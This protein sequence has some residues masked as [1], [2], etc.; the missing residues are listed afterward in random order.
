MRVKIWP[1]KKREVVQP[2]EP[3]RPIMWCDKCGYRQLLSGTTAFGVKYIPAQNHL[4]FKCPICGAKRTGPTV[5]TIIAAQ[6][7]QKRAEEAKQ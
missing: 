1:W 7:K 3:E 6:E 2:K 4:Q 5:A